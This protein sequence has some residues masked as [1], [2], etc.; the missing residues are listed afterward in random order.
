MEI[1]FSSFERRASFETSGKQN[2]FFI[3]K[4]ALA[5][6]CCALKYGQRLLSNNIFWA[7]TEKF[8]RRSLEANVEKA[9][10]F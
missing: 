8:S 2:K 5:M 9:T 10:V 3:R 6:K 1:D 4:V 7:D